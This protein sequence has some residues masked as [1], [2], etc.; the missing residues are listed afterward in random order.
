M[1][2]EIVTCDMANLLDLTRVQ[3]MQESIRDRGPAYM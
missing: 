2:V 1:T 3:N